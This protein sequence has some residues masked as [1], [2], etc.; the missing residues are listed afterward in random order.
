MVNER[1]LLFEAV[2]ELAKLTGHTALKHF[3]KLESVDRKSDGSPV[4]VADREA[5]SVAREWIAKRFPDDAILGEEF[6]ESGKPTA[7]RW[8][9][10]PI[11][12]TK[13]FVA[14]VPLWG[15]LIAV[16]E[17][18]EI[19]AGAI[20][21]AAA[22]EMIVAVQGLGAWWRGARCA[23]STV[24]SLTEATVLT[25]DDRFP[26]RP[27]RRAAWQEVADGARV[28][29]TWGDCFGYLLVATGR[30]EVMVDDRMHAW[31]SA[32]LLPILEEAG[33]VLTD[34]KGRRTGLGG[35]TIATNLVLAESVRSV[36]SR[37]E[38]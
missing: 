6:G 35:D 1:Q 33:G 17:G 5:E 10:D 27:V 8:L 3:G 34:W 7:R 12:G 29:R 32:C 30:A 26:D 22:N 23:V 25:S 2:T 14:G 28:A 13:S 36:L 9:I 38:R 4:T 31:D 20:N 24:D 11:D 21:C 18:D 15:S 37:G 16:A 19:I